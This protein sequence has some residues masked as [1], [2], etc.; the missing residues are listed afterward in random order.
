MYK[1]VFIKDL[2]KSFTLVI[3]PLPPYKDYSTI[4]LQ[5]FTEMQF[6]EVTWA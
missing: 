3:A 1:K 6:K 2:Y 5:R 4:P